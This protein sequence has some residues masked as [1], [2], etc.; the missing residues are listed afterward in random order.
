[1]YTGTYRDFHEASLTSTS[2]EDL[3]ES[4]ST[5]A[6]SVT[7]VKHSVSKFGGAHEIASLTL[8]ALVLVGIILAVAIESVKWFNSRRDVPLD[9]LL[10][11]AH[12]QKIAERTPPSSPSISY[13]NHS[14]D[15]PRSQAA[16]TTPVNSEIPLQA[17]NLSLP[18]SKSSSLDSNKHVQFA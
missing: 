3:Q 1:M 13:R 17:G 4:A 18:D 2:W 8:A 7:T 15:A 9:E 6:S 10:L 16:S 5:E 11:K 14:Y 12:E